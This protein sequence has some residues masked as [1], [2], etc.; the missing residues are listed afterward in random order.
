MEDQLKTGAAPVTSAERI[1]EL[2]VLR[3]FALLGVLLANLGWF[4]FTGNTATG[5][6]REAW[7]AASDNRAALLGLSWLVSDKANTLFGT[8]FG[9]GFWVMMERLRAKG[10]DFERIYLRRL[11]V[12]TVFGFIHMFFIWPWDILHMYALMGFALFALRGLSMKAMLW[13]GLVLGL[14]AKPTIDWIRKITGL[15][16]WSEGV[17]FNDS[18]EAAR[19]QVLHGGDYG[20]W[21]ANYYEVAKYEYVLGALVV[22]WL[23]YVL[24]RFLVG[25]WIARKGWF[26]RMGD[27]LPQVRRLCMVTLPLGL[28]M[29]AL[30][31]AMEFDFLSAPEPLPHFLHYLGVPIL[32]IGY[33][34]GLILLFHSGSWSF[35]ARMF[36]PVGR[37]ALTN[38]VMQSFLHMFVLTGIGPGLALAG[39]IGPAQVM[40]L[41]FAFFALQIVFSHLWL[42]AFRF[43]PLEWA[44][45]ALTYGEM[46]AMRRLAQA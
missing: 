7:L 16:D 33:A 27:L 14:F 13:A 39:R 1:G 2:D 22:G 28:A 42:K 26:Q 5:E 17:V 9:I 20:A 6:Q 46:P 12:L 25:A 38:Y 30:Y 32:D 18:A 35:L 29:E 3:G 36:A 45:R 41:C 23:L 44:W 24:G 8:L 37:M 34:T 21:V 11:V 31:T 19:Q 15:K 4:A 40:A 10:A 43:G